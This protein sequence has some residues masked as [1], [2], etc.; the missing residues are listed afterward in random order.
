[1]QTNESTEVV[2]NVA[3]SEETK[4]R[5]RLKPT[6]FT[7][8]R[9]MSFVT[10]VYFLLNPAKECIQ[11]RLNRFFKMLGKG[12]TRMSQQALSAARSRFDHSPFEEMARRHVVLEYSGKYELPTW[13]GYHIFGIDGS[14]VL[15]P[16]SVE[17]KTEFGVISN[18]SE[19]NQACAGVS[20]L[21]DVLHDWI[22]DASINPYPQNERESAKAHIDFLAREMAHLDKK[23]VL[24]DRG[25][26]SHELLEYLHERQ[27][28]FLMRCQKS[29]FAA[30]E[31]APMGDSVAVLANGLKIRVF[32]FV[33][34][35]DEIETLITDLF[36]FPGEELGNLY[37][38]RWNVEGKYD[39][40]KNKLQIE[41]FSGYTKNSILQDF[42]A[43]IT[44]SIIVAIAK[45]EADEKIQRRTA[46]KNNKH[47]Q[48]PNVSQLVGSLKDG[49]ILACSL[50]NASLRNAAIDR[51]IHEISLAVSLVR[52]GR[53]PHK[54][55][56]SPKKTQYPI[57]RKSNI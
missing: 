5:A 25:Y 4:D 53:P 13:K 47:R 10:V 40:L 2:R 36:D 16:N 24:F 14:C 1:M 57:N 52:R 9:I 33:L 7:R 49:F 31:R 34:S 50:P 55:S 17:L 15:L 3:E 39:V 22:I 8:N 45:Q 27:I 23:V 29:S 44:L 51:V 42:W 30:V 35:S 21:C 26:P 54:R 6:Y 28:N 18:A 41:N 11:T 56:P 12:A 19:V 38:L 32:K 48:I 20:I 43:S 37:F 46:G